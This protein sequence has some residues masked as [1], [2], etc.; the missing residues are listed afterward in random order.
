MSG[1]TK[2]MLVNQTYNREWIPGSSIDKHIYVVHELKNATEPH[3]GSI[4]SKGEV[5][6]YCERGDWNVT[7]K[8]PK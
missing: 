7:V 3:I 2:T 5:D 6:D 1:K 8:V 4:L